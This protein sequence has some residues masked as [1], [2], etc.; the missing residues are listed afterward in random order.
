MFVSLYLTLTIQLIPEVGD[1][2][3]RTQVNLLST[4]IRMEDGAFPSAWNEFV[5]DLV[6]G[7]SI[8][9][10]FFSRASSK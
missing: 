1:G 2:I 7:K 4:D 10:L 8:L 5:Q 6:K 9:E 3:F